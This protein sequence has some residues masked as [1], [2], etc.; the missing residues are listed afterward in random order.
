MNKKNTDV[1]LMIL[2]ISLIVVGIPIGMYMADS[3][4][5]WLSPTYDYTSFPDNDT[6]L[7]EAPVLGAVIST[8]GSAVTV[9]GTTATATITNET[10]IW[11]SPLDWDSVT[12]TG[13]GDLI[14]N[15]N[16]TVSDLYGSVNY[17]MILNTNSSIDLTLT[18]QAIKSDGIILTSY[19]LNTWNPGNGSNSVYWN[20]TPSDIMEIITT[21]NVRAT[22]ETWI[23][24]VIEETD[25]A[26]E[27]GDSVEFKIELGGSGHVYGI[28]SE[29]TLQ[30]TLWIGTLIFGFVALAST[31]WFNPTTKGGSWT[32]P[33]FKAWKTRGGS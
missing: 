18:L 6:D 20:W 5:S 15:L 21:M 11:D 22:E 23:R 14:L 1:A 31:P 27:I 12:M 13:A 2:A 4:N 19:D 32:K 24:L 26:L 33:K 29:K 8:E 28:S 16:K 7:L 3:W 10:V 17:Q 9:N 30:M 25:G